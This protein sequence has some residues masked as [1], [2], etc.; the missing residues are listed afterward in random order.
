MVSLA[1]FI[2][3][4]PWLHKLMMPISKW[5]VNASGYRK[6]GLRFVHPPTRAIAHDR[7]MGSSKSSGD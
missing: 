4:R 2:V 1:P 3:K 7:A 6:M 5:Y